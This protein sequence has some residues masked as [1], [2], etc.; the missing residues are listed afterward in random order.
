MVLVVSLALRRPL[1]GA[2]DIPLAAVIA[3]YALAKVLE[4][5]VHHILTLT[6]GFVSG[7]SLQH[8]ASAMAA[9][10]VIAVMQNGE[11]SAHTRIWSRKTVKI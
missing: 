5:G 7:H 9:W 10:P 4:L 6:D 11:N 1:V 3:L 8:I 2:W